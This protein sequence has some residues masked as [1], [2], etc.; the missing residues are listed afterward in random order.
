MRSSSEVMKTKSTVRP[1]KTQRIILSLELEE[2]GVIR[3]EVGI[4]RLS[5]C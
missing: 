1:S 2:L 5:N 4:I 3:V